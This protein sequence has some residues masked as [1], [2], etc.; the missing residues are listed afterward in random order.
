MEKSINR[1]YLDLDGTTDIDGDLY[2]QVG[3]ACISPDAACDVIIGWEDTSHGS[4]TETIYEDLPAGEWIEIG[5][6]DLSGDW[7]H[8]TIETLW[9]RFSFAVKADYPVR[10][11]WVRLEEEGN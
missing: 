2:N 10:I 5:P 3:L 6:Y 4:G 1:L 11:G 8:R 7:S 9:L